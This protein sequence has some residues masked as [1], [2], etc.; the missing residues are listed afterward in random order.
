MDP[1]ISSAQFFQNPSYLAEVPTLVSTAEYEPLLGGKIAEIRVREFR[2]R[3]VKLF[4]FLAQCLHR[5]AA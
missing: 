2:F 5:L 1:P 4:E 3:P